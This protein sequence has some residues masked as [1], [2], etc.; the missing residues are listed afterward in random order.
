MVNINDGG[1]G[2]DDMEDGCMVDDNIGVGN[3]ILMMVMDV[4]IWELIVM[5]LFVLQLF[6]TLPSS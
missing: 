2:D 6:V 1:Y 5:I 3:N 4:V